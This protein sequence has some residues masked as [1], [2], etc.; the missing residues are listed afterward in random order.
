[1]LNEFCLKAARIYRTVNKPLIRS[2]VDSSYEIYKDSE[3][4][5]PIATVKIK[6]IPEIK[7]FDLIF[8]VCAL[9][10]L[11]STLVRLVNFFRD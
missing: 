10:I 9:K 3:A 2:K 11:F 5:E 4:E 6:N 1:M 8:A 7:L